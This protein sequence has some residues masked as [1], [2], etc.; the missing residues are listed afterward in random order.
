MATHEE[1]FQAVKQ[2]VERAGKLAELKP[3]LVPN[4]EVPTRG[5]IQM[6]ALPGQVSERDGRRATGNAIVYD[7]AGGDT[8]ATVAGHPLLDKLCG[9]PAKKP[10]ARV[11]APAK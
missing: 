10:A 2:K 7:L 5:R 3:E 8:P 9:I 11:A 1:V 6:A 4:A